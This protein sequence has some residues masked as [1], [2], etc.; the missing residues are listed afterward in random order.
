MESH[1]GSGSATTVD[2]RT[3]ADRRM[4]SKLYVEKRYLFLIDCLNGNG[5]IDKNACLVEASTLAWVL[6]RDIGID[7]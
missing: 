6:E 3:S 7:I 2:T 4:L 5:N 1:S